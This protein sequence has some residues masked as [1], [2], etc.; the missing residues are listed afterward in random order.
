MGFS[1]FNMDRSRKVVWDLEFPK[2]CWEI[3]QLSNHCWDSFAAVWEESPL[4]TGVLRFGYK[5]G[6]RL[7]EARLSAHP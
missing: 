5:Q 2:Y 7:C 4:R 6:E 3:Y 1:A